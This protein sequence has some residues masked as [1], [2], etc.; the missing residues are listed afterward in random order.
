[1]KNVFDV[2]AVGELLIDFTPAG[3]D[4]VGDQLFVRKPGGAP[5]NV[6]AAVSRLGGRTAFIG[7]VGNDMFGSFLR[8]TLNGLNID[9]S[10]LAADPIIPTTLAFVQLDEKGD[11]SFRFYRN[12]GADIMLQTSEIPQEILEDSRIL[13]FGSVSLTSEPSR[14]ATLFAVKA[15]KESGRVISFDPNYRPPLWQSSQEAKA[16][17]T[18]GLALA[19]IVKVSEEEM[20]LLT[21]KTDLQEGS[22]ELERC[23]ASLVLISLGAKGAYFRRGN[24]AGWVPTYD[25]KTIDTNGAGDAFLG[26]VL[27]RLKGRKLRDI[28][29]LSEEKLTELLSFANAAGALATS[30]SGAIP[31]M[32][33]LEEI[34]VCRKNVPILR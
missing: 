26:A 34:E 25:V 7:K 12:P 30:R 18:A 17:M 9:I 14:S 4:S 32:P 33:T 11:R 27:F 19:D 23:G 31:A 10:G 28:R 1:M 6:L 2:T 22:L 13:H 3:S 16:Q 5:A 21:G 20:Q 15:A 29:G 24:V 8:Q